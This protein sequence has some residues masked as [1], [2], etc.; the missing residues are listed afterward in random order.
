MLKTPTSVWRYHG[1]ILLN[2]YKG[3][4][5]LSQYIS[6]NLKELNLEIMTPLPKKNIT[7]FTSVK[8]N[9]E[10]QLFQPRQ[11]VLDPQKMQIVV[12]SVYF[13]QIKRSK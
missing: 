1:P 2:P 13:L 9:E 6:S 5:L 8:Y 3:I 7:S 4:Y 11:Q 12:E 10:F